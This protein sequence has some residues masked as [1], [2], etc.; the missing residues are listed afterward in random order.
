MGQWLDKRRMVRLWRCS[1]SQLGAGYA[2]GAVKCSIFYIEVNKIFI[3]S[4]KSIPTC[5][6]CCCWWGP[7]ASISDDSVLIKSRTVPWQSYLLFRCWLRWRVSLNCRRQLRDWNQ[8]GDWNRKI[9]GSKCFIPVS[10]AVFRLLAKAVF[11]LFIAVG[12]LWNLLF[13]HIFSH[14]VLSSITLNIIIIVMK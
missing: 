6:D 9:S 8:D 10:W 5:L 11:N 14:L 12:S 2:L 3:C 13:K 1:Y 4:I 7:R